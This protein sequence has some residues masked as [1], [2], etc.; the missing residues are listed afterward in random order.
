MVVKEVK[1]KGGWWTGGRLVVRQGG[2]GTTSVAYGGWG[3]RGGASEDDV[4]EGVNEDGG[5]EGR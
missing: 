4:D 2:S 3:W 5:G 1:E